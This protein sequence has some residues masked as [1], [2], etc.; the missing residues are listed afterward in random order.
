MKSLLVLSALVLS[1][2]AHASMQIQNFQ[3]YVTSPQVPA[4]SPEPVYMMCPNQ[5]DPTKPAVKYDVNWL[6]MHHP[7]VG[8][9]PPQGPV[10]GEEESLVIHAPGT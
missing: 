4:A 10:N 8:V 6:E 9:S 2:S 7:S 3:G 5:A 1:M